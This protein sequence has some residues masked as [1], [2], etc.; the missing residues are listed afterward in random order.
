MCI[1]Y[2][3]FSTFSSLLRTLLL[4]DVELEQR[5]WR[6]PDFSLDQS[7]LNTLQSCD[8]QVNVFAFALLPKYKH[9]LSLF[10][11]FI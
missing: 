4:H 5:P 11:D 6:R 2:L 3:S 8:L 1:F 7:K 9:R 10:L